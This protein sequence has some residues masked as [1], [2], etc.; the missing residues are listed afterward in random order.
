M[1]TELAGK[2]TQLPRDRSNQSMQ[3]LGQSSTEVVAMTLAGTTAQ[4][5]I[6]AGSE[7]VE[8]AALADCHISFGA[9]PTA[10]TNSPAFPKGCVVYKLL[11]DQ[12]KLAA[13]LASGAS[14]AQLTVTRL[15]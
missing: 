3:V 4:V 11:P 8:V 15:K 10:T 9:N 1:T 2:D 6:P 14:A 7:I 12:T 13:I 5:T